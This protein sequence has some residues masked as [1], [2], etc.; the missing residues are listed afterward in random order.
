[1]IEEISQ[2][3]MQNVQSTAGMYVAKKSLDVMEM[4]GQMAVA[5]IQNAGGA[6]NP[7]GTGT[8]V[9]KYV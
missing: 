5:L 8:L 1:M 9:N 6:T 2:R 4:Q 3:V 7:A